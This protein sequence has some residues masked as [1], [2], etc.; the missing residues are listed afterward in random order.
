MQI[1]RWRLVLFVQSG[2]NPSIALDNGIRAVG[3]VNFQ[4]PF[5]I[6]PIGWYALD[7]N[8]YM[9]EFNVTRES[10]AQ[11]TV[12]SRELAQHNPIAQFPKNSDFAR[13]HGSTTDS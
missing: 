1:M 7:C 10:I 2:G 3:D 5:G 12:K 11:V 8:R 9:A 6:P 4:A 13:S